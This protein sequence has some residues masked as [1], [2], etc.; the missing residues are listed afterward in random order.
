MKRREV[1]IRHS[2]PFTL[3]SRNSQPRPPDASFARRQAAVVPVPAA[4][5]TQAL[6]RLLLICRRAATTRGTIRWLNTT[7][8]GCQSLSTLAAVRRCQ[9][10]SLS[11]CA[12]SRKMVMR[13]A[14]TERQG[15]QALAGS[16]RRSVAAVAVR[17]CQSLLPARHVAGAVLGCVWPSRAVSSAVAVVAAVRL[18]LAR[19]HRLAAAV[20]LPSPFQGFT[21]PARLNAIRTVIPHIV[22]QRADRIGRQTHRCAGA[23]TPC[24]RFPNVVQVQATNRNR[25]AEQ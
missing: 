10:P 8:S 14:Q 15:R 4:G 6:S 13:A 16:G 19:H 18:A 3:R 9:R 1:N 12:L 24:S 20:S 7:P 23:S 2:T 5:A 25:L 11:V 17:G 22:H 21:Q